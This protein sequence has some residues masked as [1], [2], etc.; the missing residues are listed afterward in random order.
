MERNPSFTQLVLLC[1]W[2]LKGNVFD[3]QKT[4]YV[5]ESYVS[6]DFKWQ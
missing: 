2:G 6:M 1:E 5:G 4:V 3:I